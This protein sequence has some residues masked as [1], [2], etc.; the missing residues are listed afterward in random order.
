VGIFPVILERLAFVRED[1][2]AARSDRGGSVVLSREDIA[3]RP[4]DV[5][6]QRGQRL[7]QHRGLD[8][9]VQRACDAG[10]LERLLVLVFFAHGHQAGH[11]G[12]GDRDFLA[13]E[14]RLGDIGYLVVG[15][16]GFKRSFHDAF[17]IQIADRM[18]ALRV[19]FPHL[20]VADL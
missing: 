11:L 14:F 8:R 20:S 10:P 18:G 5:G 4:A 9:H 13:A 3:R 16:R 15:K 1:R 6:T 17:S 7:D 12:F 2:N 19:S